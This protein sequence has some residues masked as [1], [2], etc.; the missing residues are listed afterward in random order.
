MSA[1]PKNLL[2][3]LDTSFFFVPPGSCAKILRAPQCL[4]ER[5]EVQ[6]VAPIPPTMPY[7]NFSTCNLLL[8]LWQHSVR[9]PFCPPK[10]VV[11][12]EVPEKGIS[13]LSPPLPCCTIFR[14]SVPTFLHAYGTFNFTTVVCLSLCLTIPALFACTV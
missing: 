10:K 1:P 6:T 11:T 2:F 7:Y 12:R 9:P 5:R 4:G 13:F 3:T 14:T 8:F